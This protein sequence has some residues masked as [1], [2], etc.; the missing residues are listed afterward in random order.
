MA[1]LCHYNKKKVM[2][3]EVFPMMTPDPPRKR[4]SKETTRKILEVFRQSTPMQIQ[5]FIACFPSAESP[6]INAVVDEHGN[7]LLHYACENGFALA[8]LLLRERADPNLTNDSGMTSL[9]VAA[10]IGS[11][12]CMNLL[13]RYTG[14]LTYKAIEGSTP[15]QIARAQGHYELAHDMEVALAAGLGDGALHPPKIPPPLPPQ[16]ISTNHERQV[17]SPSQSPVESSLDS[18]VPCSAEKTCTHP[19]QPHMAA[20]YQLFLEEE[21]ARLTC[22]AKLRRYYQMPSTASFCTYVEVSG[23]THRA[24]Q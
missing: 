11:R 22:D 9:H 7:T 12:E 15:V 18:F 13:V 5:E 16:T 20:L 10:Q 14:N 4:D 24:R 8:A 3:D 17:S 21:Q 1:K 6:V 23:D 19:S 2:M